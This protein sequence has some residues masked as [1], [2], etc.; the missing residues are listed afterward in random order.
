MKFNTHRFIA[1]NST[2]H[3]RLSWLVAR[4]RKARCFPPPLALNLFESSDSDCRP[5]AEIYCVCRKQPTFYDF[6]STPRSVG[7]IRRCGFA[8][9]QWLIVRVGTG[10]FSSSWRS[11][12]VWKFCVVFFCVDCLGGWLRVDCWNCLIWLAKI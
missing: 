9:T 10:A 12:W 8:R 4:F 7:W 5:P 2:N 11:F 1:S 3:F 6:R